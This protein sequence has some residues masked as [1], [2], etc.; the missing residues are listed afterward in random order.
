MQLI[1][2]LA[3]NDHVLFTCCAC[4]QVSHERKRTVFVAPLTTLESFRFYDED[5]NEYEF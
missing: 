4:F 1:T 3:P 5:E 2:F